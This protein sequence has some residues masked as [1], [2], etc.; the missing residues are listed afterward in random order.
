MSLDLG[1]AIAVSIYWQP[2][3]IIDSYKQGMNDKTA[4][5]ISVIVAI[6]TS[7]RVIE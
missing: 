7:L 2:Q 1:M 3:M 4:P 6:S 5:D